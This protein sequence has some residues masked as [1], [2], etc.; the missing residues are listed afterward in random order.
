MYKQQW[1]NY[2]IVAQLDKQTE[3]YRVALFLYSIGSEAVKTYNSF[4]LNEENRRKLSEI[5]KELDKY[6]IG[7]TSET[8]ER[9]MYVCR[10]TEN[11]CTIVQFLY[12]FT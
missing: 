5:I 8:Y 3:E 6:A 2:T 7:E 4:D 9:Y 11:T 1:E 12:L 10:R